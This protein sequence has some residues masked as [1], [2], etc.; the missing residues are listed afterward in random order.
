MIKIIHRITPVGMDASQMH[1]R[2]ASNSVSETS[3][4]GLV[5]KSLGRLLGE[6]SE[7]SQ[8]FSDMAEKMSD[9]GLQT[10]ALSGYLFIY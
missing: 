10:K 1:L 6:V 8:I 9:I 2:H 5:C 7:I 3:Q 4:R